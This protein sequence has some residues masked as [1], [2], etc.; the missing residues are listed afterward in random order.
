MSGQLCKII[1]PLGH[2]RFSIELKIIRFSIKVFF[3]H[4]GADRFFFYWLQSKNNHII[5]RA[6]LLFFAVFAPI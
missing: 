3:F 2:C 1:V 5:E 4:C 6:K